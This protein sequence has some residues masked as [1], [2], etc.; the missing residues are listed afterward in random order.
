MVN[1]AAA[2][3]LMTRTWLNSLMQRYDLR[4]HK[5]LGQNYVVDPNTIRRIVRLSG[6]QPGDQVIEIGPGLGS[7]TLGC[8][9][10]GADVLALEIDDRVLPALSEVVGDKARVLH[11][12]ALTVEWSQLL[13]PGP[14]MVIANL[15]YNVAASVVLNMLAQAPAARSFLVMVQREVAQ[16]F[17]AKPGTK[18]YGIPSVKT[19]FWGTATMVGDVPA[20]VFVPKPNVASSLVRIDRHPT[21]ALPDPEFVFPLVQAGFAQRRKTLRNSLSGM[22]SAEAFRLA[23]IDPGDRPEQLGIEAW[24]RLSEAVSSS[25][26]PSG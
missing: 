26:K 11:C 15:P 14:Y 5:T 17:V 25:A 7:L 21:S 9:E 23:E 20:D 4:P 6:I 16:R 1:E 22:V 18:A 10:V 24:V 8:I 13:G 19:A 3:A 12:D 2:P